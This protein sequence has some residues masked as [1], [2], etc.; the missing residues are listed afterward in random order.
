MLLGARTMSMFGE[1]FFREKI[2]KVSRSI[3]MEWE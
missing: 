3:H 2:G 1:R